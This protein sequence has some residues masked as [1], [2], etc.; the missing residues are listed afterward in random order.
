LAP[1]QQA[2]LFAPF[3]QARQDRPGRF[4]GTGLGLTICR[5]L[6]SMM[7]GSIELSSAAGRGSCF[8][9]RVVL[10]VVEAPASSAVQEKTLHPVD[11]NALKNL[12]VLVVDDHPANRMLLQSQLVS[13]GCTVET[14]NDGQTAFAQ[15]AGGGPRGLGRFDLILTDCSMPVMSGEDLAR[16]IRA[17]EASENATKPVRIVGVTANAQPE[18]VASALAAGMTL[19]LVK[20]LG[21]DAL[22]D[23]LSLAAREP[24]QDRVSFDPALVDGFG[25]QA[26]AL[27][28]A[29]L[30]DLDEAREA[31]ASREFGHLARIAHRMKGAAF[32]VGATPFADACLA[33]QQAC[34][35]PTEKEIDAAYDRFL[36][37]AMA[38]DAAL[39]QRL[40]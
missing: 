24:G 23:A 4:G 40:A 12:R 14:A 31:L 15:W 6:M 33:L 20:P 25:A 18:A 5:R 9:A 32:V 16:A 13:L 17:R 30:Q 21:L 38:L 7:G 35:A 22:C 39:T 8:T 29:N 37:E 1:D 27:K 36:H 11:A 10:P 26:G 19:C 28:T 2:L 3:T 34:D